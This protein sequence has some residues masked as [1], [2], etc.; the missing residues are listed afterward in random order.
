MSRHPETVPITESRAQLEQIVLEAKMLA[1]VTHVT[2]ELSVLP[3]HPFSQSP[4]PSPPPSDA[5]RLSIHTNTPKRSRLTSL[6]LHPLHRRQRG[7]LRPPERPGGVD[8]PGGRSRARGGQGAAGRLHPPESG[9]L[10]RDVLSAHAASCAPLSQQRGLRDQPAGLA[11]HVY[12]RDRARFGRRSVEDDRRV[13]LR[14][15]H[16]VAKALSTT[17][18]KTDRRRLAVRDR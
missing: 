11:P 7:A 12:P 2:E 9:S 3:L 17:P 5:P 15:V 13:E 16:R 4:R 6:A 10:R 14:L 18:A 8:E 1:G